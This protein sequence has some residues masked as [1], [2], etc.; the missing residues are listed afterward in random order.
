MNRLQM[1]TSTN[2]ELRSERE[3]SDDLVISRC[4]KPSIY[5]KLM[6]SHHQAI[7]DVDIYISRAA[8]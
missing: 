4:D 8:P 2:N 1:M 5:N 3:V 6:C 7:A